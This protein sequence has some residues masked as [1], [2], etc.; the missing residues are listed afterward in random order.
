MTGEIGIRL[1][2]KK[3]PLKNHLLCSMYHTL[4]IKR[5]LPCN[6]A[7]TPSLHYNHSLFL[8]LLISL[9]IICADRK[10]F[11][12]RL[13]IKC[14]QP[15]F[16]FFCRSRSVKFCHDMMCLILNT[17]T[18]ASFA[19]DYTAKSPGL[20]WHPECCINTLQCL[21]ISSWTQMNYGC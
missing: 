2:A 16:F 4:K 14:V 5:P 17:Q 1:W 18:R 12:D 3:T 13:L 8:C 7:K 6:T 10:C 19:S 21:S 20:N 9:Q 15:F 11:Q